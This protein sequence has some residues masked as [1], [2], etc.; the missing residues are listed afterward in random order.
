MGRSAK[1]GGVLQ[2]SPRTEREPQMWQGSMGG[3][4]NNVRRGCIQISKQPLK[5]ILLE[6]FQSGWHNHLF[7]DV[8]IRWSI[9]HLVWGLCMHG[10]RSLIVEGMCQSEAKSVQSS[11]PNLVMARNRTV[12][13]RKM[14]NWS[15]ALSSSMPCSLWGTHGH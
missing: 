12:E 7:G 14:V 13:R 10:L 15:T 1:W 6:W 9:N 4:P 5:D 3:C 2:Y 8:L 11:W